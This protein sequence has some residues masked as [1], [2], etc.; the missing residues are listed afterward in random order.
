MT[1]TKIETLFS[2]EEILF[3][4]LRQKRFLEVHEEV[5]QD[6]KEQGMLGLLEID[7]DRY[8]RMKNAPH[9]L[10]LEQINRKLAPIAEL[11]E[12]S[13]PKEYQEVLALIDNPLNQE[14]DDD[15]E[16]EEDL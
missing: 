5:M 9:I 11:I 12:E 4:Y 10:M 8:I 2:N 6:A 16:Q 7:T 15:D 14:E 13:M 3:I 1:G